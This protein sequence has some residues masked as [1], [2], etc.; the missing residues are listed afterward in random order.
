MN[1]KALFGMNKEEL[2]KVKEAEK[3]E[4]QKVSTAEKYRELGYD[5]KDVMSALIKEMRLGNLNEAMYWGRVME[6]AGD[7]WNLC[8]RLLI[9]SFEDGFG[10]GVQIYSAACWQAFA[11]IRDD[12]IWFAWVERLCRATKFWEVPEGEERETAYDKA[13]KELKAGKRRPIPDY[14]K[15]CHCKAG[16]EMKAEKGYMDNRFS[17]DG[18]GRWQMIRMYKRLG[19]LDPRDKESLKALQSYGKRS[20]W[21]PKIMENREGNY[22][23]ESQTG[24]G[25]FYKVQ[26]DLSS[27][28][29]PHY[30]QRLAGTGKKCKH[31]QRVEEYLKKEGIEIKEPE[32][33][34]SDIPF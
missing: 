23:V 31:M 13:D 29:C 30:V 9:F 24:D 32:K 22:L 21:K 5:Q 33:V 25:N 16:Y 34:S 15:D 19:K 18:Y 4:A 8:R 11:A 2:K 28:E 14:A 10:E 12:N 17:G 27:C 6:E 26:A 1:Q 3:R 7:A 20:Q